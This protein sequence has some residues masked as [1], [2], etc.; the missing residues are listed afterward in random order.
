MSPTIAKKAE[1]EED[2]S[3]EAHLQRI[4]A[5]CDK[6]VLEDSAKKDILF[7]KSGEEAALENIRVLLELPKNTD[8]SLLT[9]SNL[10]IGKLIFCTQVNVFTAFD[11]GTE[12]QALLLGDTP[13]AGG[14]DDIMEYI[15][16]SIDYYL[17]ERQAAD[18]KLFQLDD[19]GQ[20]TGMLSPILALLGCDGSR[21]L[22]SFIKKLH[23][24]K[25]TCSE[26]RLI[27]TVSIAA[28]KQTLSPRVTSSLGKCSHDS[29]VL[30]S[31]A[32][33]VPT[34]ATTGNK[35]REFDILLS[36]TAPLSVLQSRVA[37]ASVKSI[38]ATPLE[39]LQAEVSDPFIAAVRAKLNGCYVDVAYGAMTVEATAKD[40]S[41]PFPV[42]AEYNFTMGSDGKNR[43]GRPVASAF[44]LSHAFSAEF[45]EEMLASFDNLKFAK[46]K[47]SDDA[48]YIRAATID[49]Q[50]VFL[51]IAGYLIECQPA[52]GSERK[53]IELG[54]N[55]L[56][57]QSPFLYRGGIP[58]APPGSI[59]N[60]ALTFS[61]DPKNATFG[62]HSDGDCLTCALPS[63]D[64][65]SPENGYPLPA[66][67]QLQVVTFAF[68]DDPT[69]QC[70][71]TWSLDKEGTR[72]VARH[73]IG[74]NDMHF[75]LFGSNGNGY[76][77]RVRYLGGKPGSKRT[78]V[79]LRRLVPTT[80]VHRWLQ[81]TR[82]HSISSATV[83]RCI[84][85]GDY[86]YS[87]I[88]QA[89]GP[90]CHG[91]VE[92]VKPVNLLSQIYSIHEGKKPTRV[93]LKSDSWSQMK[94]G[95]YTSLVEQLGLRPPAQRAC[96]RERKW[97]SMSHK[98][99]VRT[100]LTVHNTLVFTTHAL[101]SDPKRVK[102]T[103][104]P[105]L[106]EIG[107]RPLL[108]GEI[109]RTADLNM[110]NDARNREL[111]SSNSDT[112]NVIHLSK[113][114]KNVPK[115]IVASAKQA[116]LYSR[117]ESED[118][119]T[120][121]GCVVLC[122]S[123]GSQ[124]E[125]GELAVSM[126][127]ATP[128]DSR[129]NVA[130]AQ[131]LTT[132]RN[133]VLLSI[134][135]GKMPVAVFAKADEFACDVKGRS[136]SPC[137]LS[138]FLG[139][140]YADRAEY[141][142][143]DASAT[144]ERFENTLIT[145]PMEY[146][147]RSFLY[148]DHLEVTLRPLFGRAQYDTIKEGIKEGGKPFKKLTFD[149]TSEEKIS[150]PLSLDELALYNNGEL[151]APVLREKYITS[152]FQES[153]GG[154]EDGDDETAMHKT[155]R[156]TVAELIEVNKFVSSA[157]ALRYQGS[158]F[159]DAGASDADKIARP[160]KDL[161][162]GTA[163]CKSCLPMSSRTLD[164]IPLYLR[165]K[166]AGMGLESLVDG[167]CRIEYD[168]KQ[169]AHRQIASR[170][171]H[172]AL[173]L[174]VTG[175]INRHEQHDDHCNEGS[176]LS[177]QEHSDSLMKYIESTLAASGS[178]A[179]WRSDQHRQ[180]I[181]QQLCNIARLAAFSQFLV[182]AIPAFVDFTLGTEKNI[183]RRDAVTTLA[184]K[185]LQG[186]E[187]THVTCNT[188]IH[189]NN[190]PRCCFL[191]HQGLLDVQEIFSRLTGPVA[192]DSVFSGAGGIDAKKLIGKTLTKSSS[193]DVW[194]LVV[195]EVSKQGRDGLS[196]LGLTRH[197]GIVVHALNGREFNSADGEHFGCKGKSAIAIAHA[198]RCH[199]KQ[200]R[201]SKAHCHPHRASSQS[202]MTGKRKRAWD[203]SVDIVFGGVV[204]SFR[205]LT[206]TRMGED[207]KPLLPGISLPKYCDPH[208]HPTLQDVAART[209][210]NA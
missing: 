1:F 77:H 50:P 22:S 189:S 3:P 143:L 60:A 7:L 47:G 29:V 71:I 192:S 131:D 99:S 15:G 19:G 27:F 32:T 48:G 46:K 111:I 150:F 30:G 125:S 43:A 25:L 151:T 62:S 175:R 44:G 108:P 12:E 21:S 142:S 161:E 173:I 55:V 96:L 90:T 200:P 166:A 137:H 167:C 101:P 113:N 65:Y 102:E 210:R 198:S 34:P 104:C 52:S 156:M 54:N 73:V 171:L 202:S 124:M 75:Q 31:R 81:A 182:H 16:P 172:E 183:S 88:L 40:A 11:M 107:G 17:N 119:H 8:K 132:Y 18:K 97:L 35:A 87:G 160:L 169:S 51:K 114:Y 80:S 209:K 152:L 179:E 195:E 56:A 157:G 49:D 208:R 83:P 194:A 115:T 67:W 196:I 204:D 153:G 36:S 23:S 199:S 129:F 121:D 103:I 135:R 146:R 70:E 74:G 63:G 116:Q 144:E 109:Y 37:S 147:Q 26:I 14:G 76:H 118:P 159:V 191:S 164:L 141:M 138:L 174:R 91:I 106:F 72:E 162:L 181:P 42:L 187:G 186:I 100:F 206:E 79:T 139:Y 84:H 127:S 41:V 168:Y 4:L 85:A 178:T 94:V 148:E 130:T 98:D 188:E 66:D 203:E 128:G 33:D 205:K 61:G 185:L 201:A 122:G 112:A 158:G 69:L 184:T 78:V 93:T 24:N 105:R 5:F 165:R 20:A 134:V 123:G 58:L 154:G 155:H 207:G 28:A 180:Q 64:T 57:E 110:T 10:I 177:L 95:E 163:L 13:F 39:S 176:M 92:G 120:E 59:N 2:N 68:S 133:R 136:E 170:L 82:M 117:G 38:Q 45:K 193:L 89:E 126:A 190:Y 6:S 53:L 145:D 197:R 9:W 149:S 86:R 140:Y